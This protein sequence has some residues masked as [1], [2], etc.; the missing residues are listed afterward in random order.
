MQPQLAVSS[1]IVDRV[2][3]RWPEKLWIVRHGHL[4]TSAEDLRTRLV[5]E[6]LL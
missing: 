4:F 2:R 3:Q 5:Q 6:G 1:G